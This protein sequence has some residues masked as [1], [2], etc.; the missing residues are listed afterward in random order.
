MSDKV[1]K[2]YFKIRNN[3]PNEIIFSLRQ[4]LNNIQSAKANTSVEF[5]EPLIKNWAEQVKIHNSQDQGGK[6]T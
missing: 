4:Y 1:F 5:K 2:K 3:K 6:R